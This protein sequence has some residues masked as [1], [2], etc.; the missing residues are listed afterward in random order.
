MSKRMPKL[1]ALVFF[2]ATVGAVPVLTVSTA[3]ADGCYKCVAG[4]SD[5]CRDYCRYTG[6]DTFAAHKSCESKGCKISPGGGSAC[7]TDASAKICLA[8]APGR[9]GAG[10]TVAAIAWCAAPPRS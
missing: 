5:A 8:P 9:G 3:Q 7:P 4:S 2:L 10:T 6:P 1:N